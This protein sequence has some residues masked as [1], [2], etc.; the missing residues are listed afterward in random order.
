[1]KETEV[2][3]KSLSAKGPG[4]AVTEN[5]GV[6]CA[7]ESPLPLSYAIAKYSNHAKKGGIKKL[8]PLR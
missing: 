8:S 4:E 2:K 5:T 1:M 3:V 7:G 6:A